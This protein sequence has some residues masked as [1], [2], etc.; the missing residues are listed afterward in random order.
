MQVGLLCQQF[1]KFRILHIV[2]R[3]I[4]TRVLPPLSFRGPDPDSDYSGNF[5]VSAELLGFLN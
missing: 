3:I 2:M 1:R 5:R 4:V